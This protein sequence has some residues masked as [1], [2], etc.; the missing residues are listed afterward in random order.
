MSF[1]GESVRLRVIFSV[2]GTQVACIPRTI[3]NSCKAVIFSLDVMH[4]SN[5]K[6]LHELRDQG[7]VK[8]DRL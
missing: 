3:L 1:P 5:E 2:P 8:V 4:Y 6:L 7:V